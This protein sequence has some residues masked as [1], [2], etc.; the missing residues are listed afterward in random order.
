MVDYINND[1][2]FEVEAD[3]VSLDSFRTHDK[4]NPKLWHGGKIDSRARVKLLDIAWDFVDTLAVPWVK[5]K[6]ITVTGSL[7]NYNW[8]KYSDIDV[9]IV[10]DFKKVWE[11]REDFVRDYF[12]AK[13]N[14]WADSHEGLKVYGFPVEISVENAS[15]KA[16]S[17]GVFSLE[18][19]EWV[20]EPEDLSD[21]RLNAG[22]IKEKSAEIMTGIDDEIRRIRKA[23]TD[24]VRER[25]CD[26]LVKIFDKLKRMRKSGLDTEACEMSSGNIIWKVLRREGYIDKLWDT[27]NSTYDKVNSLR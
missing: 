1:I 7:A 6:D 27:V 21:A 16:K 13:K 4:L 19:N 17:S 9:H 25:A 20:S 3:D 22:Y 18:D 5:P 10:M 12:N 24:A 15:E 8:S 2:I 26:S 11:K 14:E 23:K